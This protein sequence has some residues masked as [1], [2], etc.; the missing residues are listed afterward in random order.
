MQV[1]A[2]TPWGQAAEPVEQQEREAGLAI[3]GDR[4]LALR[5]AAL[6]ALPDKLV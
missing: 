5:Y 6:F 2:P 4:A 3:E 1:H